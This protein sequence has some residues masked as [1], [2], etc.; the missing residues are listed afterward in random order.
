MLIRRLLYVVGICC[1]GAMS[2]LAQSGDTIEITAPQP[3]SLLRGTVTI[4]GTANLPAQTGYFLQYRELDE[5]LLP[6]GGDDALWSPVTAIVQEPVVDGVLGEWDTGPVDDGVY[7]LQLVVNISDGGS[8]RVTLEPVRVQNADV[9]A[10][11]ARFYTGEGILAPTPTAETSIVIAT[12]PP[13]A[14]SPT[15]A[16]T[17]VAGVSVTALVQA[18]VREG[19]FIL[20]PPVGI[21]EQGETV[22]AIGRSSRSSWLYIRLSDGTE[23]FIADSTLSINGD[24]FDLPPVEPPPLP[25]TPTFTPT[26]TST[27]LP[28][29]ANLSVVSFRINPSSPDCGETI[30]ITAEIQNTGTGPSFNSARIHVEEH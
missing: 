4:T 18:N 30:R 14:A 1:M 25:I 8:A 24:V 15:I 10:E 6:V 2:L 7:Q 27:P 11:G 21:L 29:Q 16:V 22:Q 5:D 20:Y 28:V 23:G 3:V 12:P 9:L 17:T 26:P 19:D 13:S